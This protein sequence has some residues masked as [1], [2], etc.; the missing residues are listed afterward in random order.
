[1]SRFFFLFLNVICLSACQLFGPSAAEEFAVHGDLHTLRYREQASSR[2]PFESFGD[3]AYV[4]KIKEKAREI[5]KGSAYDIVEQGKKPSTLADRDDL[6]PRDN[7][8]VIRCR[9]FH[10]DR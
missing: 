3:D 5:C 10:K 4:K 2:S 8:W 1:M 9:T 6:D 7:F